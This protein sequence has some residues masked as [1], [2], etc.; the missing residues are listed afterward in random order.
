[1]ETPKMHVGAPHVSDR[2]VYVF[3]ASLTVYLPNPD[4]SSTCVRVDC[5]H[6]HSS[7]EAS[8]TCAER[9][10][11]RARRNPRSFPELAA[12]LDRREQAGR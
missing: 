6:Q 12:E 2:R 10:A 11:G 9:L 7:Y 1:M 8:K 3:A 5:G 4:G